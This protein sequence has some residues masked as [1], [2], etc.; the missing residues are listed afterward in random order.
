MATDF[1]ESPQR[2]LIP[3]FKQL[4]QIDNTSLFEAEFSSLNLSWK[5]LGRR[6]DRA[7]SKPLRQLTGL[8][9]SFV[10]T[11]TELSG[12]HPELPTK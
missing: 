12:G 6:Q 9:V 1:K 2:P 11:R 8:F 3:F 5:T 7:Q 10:T 4:F